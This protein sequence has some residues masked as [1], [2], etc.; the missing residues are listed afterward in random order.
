MQDRDCEWKDHIQELWDGK[1]QK[2][3]LRS[4]KK[5]RYSHLSAGRSRLEKLLSF[6]GNGE[7]IV[8]EI[9]VSFTICYIQYT[10]GLQLY[11]LKRYIGKV[12]ESGFQEMKNGLTFLVTLYRVG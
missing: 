5:C 11:L 7:K 10:I 8:C 12:T 1:I 6:L 4:D 2:V 9:K 3:D